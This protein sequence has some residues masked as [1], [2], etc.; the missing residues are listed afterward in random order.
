M[1]QQGAKQDQE[2]QMILTNVLRVIAN[3]RE[4]EESISFIL[5]S[6]CQ[7][8]NALGG[9]FYLFDEPHLLIPLT[10]DTALLETDTHFADEVVGLEEGLHFTP[11][12][13]SLVASSYQQWLL[14]PIRSHRNA[15]VSVLLLVFESSN[16]LKDDEQKLL[17]S[18]VDA[19]KVIT[20]HARSTARHEKLSR[21]QHEFTRIVSHDLRSP[22]TYMQGF[23][24]ML[25]ANSDGSLGEKQLY[26][27]E[28]ILTGITQMTGLVDN[29][30]DAG[31]FDPETGFYE[32]ERA[33]CDLVEMVQR[34][35][36]NHIVPAEK[37]ELT[38]TVKTADDVP[39]IY[40][41]PNML[42]RAL[43]N[44]IDNA[45]K[46]T[47]NGG[48]IEMGVNRRNHHIVL[49]VTDDGYGIS[50]ENQKRLFARHVRIP[51][52]EHKR[53]KGSGLGLFIVSSVAQ[54]HNGRAWVESVE[55]QGSTFYISIPLDES[56]LHIPEDPNPAL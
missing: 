42:E 47:P 28:K 1:T 8:S 11:P 24:S 18:L 2:A 23:A 9:C 50:P 6:A 30:Q 25:E 4:L 37:Q 32:M 52:R 17:L 43:I 33:P 34:I 16:A 38:I 15:V 36:S 12:I 45:I 56:N 20:T 46:Y 54:R 48:K 10:F 22:M 21:N 3:S 19:L 27:V 55:G 7:L 39:I 35:V 51:R 29:I 26:Y 49:S 14:A 44:L 41:D 5:Q 40:A 53:V 31:R 13:A